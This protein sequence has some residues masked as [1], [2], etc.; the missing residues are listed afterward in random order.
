MWLQPS[1]GVYRGRQP[2]LFTL[3]DTHTLSVSDPSS[4]PWRLTWDW[5]CFWGM[6]W[7][8]SLCCHL[9]LPMR[10]LC[11]SEVMPKL[12]LMK[13]LQLQTVLIQAGV[14][15]L[16]RLVFLLMPKQFT[17]DGGEICEENW[18]KSHPW[19]NTS[20][21]ERGYL[22]YMSSGRLKCPIW[23]K[24]NQGLQHGSLSSRWVS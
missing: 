6:V 10:K 16:V 4:L 14:S 18:G 7:S 8:F 23:V 15:Y 17:H 21:M 5:V 3:A 13:S 24:Q 19:K 22:L 12:C 2:C 20:M 1:K 9:L 11:W